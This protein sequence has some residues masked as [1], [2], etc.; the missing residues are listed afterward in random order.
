MKK[1]TSYLKEDSDIVNSIT[2]S[3]NDAM[4]KIEQIIS[5]FNDMGDGRK[6]YTLELLSVLNSELDQIVNDAIEF[7]DDEEYDEEYDEMDGM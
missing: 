2:K 4:I 5:D 3:K 7:D 1:F 6:Q